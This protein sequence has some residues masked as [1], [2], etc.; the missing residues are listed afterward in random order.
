MIGTRK[1]LWFFPLAAMAVAAGGC[2]SSRFAGTQRMNTVPQNLPPVQSTSVQSSA[3]PP[4]QGQDGT[5]T[6]DTSFDPYN[7]GNSGFPNSGDP[8]LMGQ[9]TANADGSFVSLDDTGVTTPGGR[10][11]SGGLTPTKLL[12][13]WTV[14]AGLDNCRLNLTQTTKS[15]TD[16]YRA[17]APNCA[18]PV[19]ALV[20]SWQLT[21]NQVQLY[22]ESGSIVGALQLSGN[23][24]IGT[25]SGGIAVSMEG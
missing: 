20:S 21:G 15:G 1:V 13:V 16:R 23:R 9:Q 12:G 17:S 14:R 10:D 4:L 25:L 5:I 11:L 8:A 24:F 18:V 2:T 7:T 19:L 22:D 6:A 3:L